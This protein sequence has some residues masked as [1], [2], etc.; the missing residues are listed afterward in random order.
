LSE[1]FKRRIGLI[2]GVERDGCAN[3]IL[4]ETIRDLAEI[5]L[6]QSHDVEREATLTRAKFEK[7][8]KS[9]FQTKNSQLYSKPPLSEPMLAKKRELD[10]TVSDNG[11]GVCRGAWC[12]APPLSRL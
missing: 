10:R 8:A 9:F 1:A 11:Y 6:P 2:S 12:N 5:S 3:E 4:D 7:F